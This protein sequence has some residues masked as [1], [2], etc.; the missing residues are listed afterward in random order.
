M[1]KRILAGVCNFKI[2]MKTTFSVSLILCISF[3]ALPL[4]SHHYI[5][6][7]DK[8]IYK[9]GDSMNLHLMV[10]EPFHFEFERELQKNMTPHFMLYTGSDSVNLLPAIPDSANPILKMKIGFTGLGLIEMQ[11]S[12]STIEETPGS[13]QRYLNEEKITGIMFDSLKWT[14]K[15]VKEKYSR[16]IKSLVLS[17]Q[18]GNEN[19]YGKVIGQHL[20][21]ILLVNPY[22]LSPGQHLVT[23]LL[24]EGKPLHKEWLTATFQKKDGSISEISIQTDA[25]GIA[26]FEAIPNAI[27]YLHVV[28]MVKSKEADTDYESVWASYSFLTALK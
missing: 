21:I 17:E 16:C 20:E 14:K 9:K 13:F 24:W 11:R 26:S 1:K 22:S 27:Y 25:R 18:S 6:V 15:V 28:R 8:F 3:F 10:G 2:K 5:L 7:P 12:P 23:K 19:L 4:F